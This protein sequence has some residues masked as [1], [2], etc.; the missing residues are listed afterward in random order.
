MVLVT[1]RSV[2]VVR[3]SVILS[4]LALLAGGCRGQF[5][6]SSNVTGTTVGS[7]PA[8]TPSTDLA[9]LE[10]L[11]ERVT[12]EAM[13]PVQANVVSTSDFACSLGD[14]DVGSGRRAR[15]TLNLVRPSDEQAGLSAM[16]AGFHATNESDLGGRG[17]VTDD[18]A[19]RS[20]SVDFAVDGLGV[21]VSSPGG[22][23]DEIYI[24]DAH[25]PCRAP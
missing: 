22:L 1:L 8:G 11:I 4:G 16:A 13:V 24:L 17:V 25:G 12:M 14:F 5:A 10:K 2:R 6:T 7:V 19:T 21:H 9:L 3:V 23:S 18:S 15:I 20:K